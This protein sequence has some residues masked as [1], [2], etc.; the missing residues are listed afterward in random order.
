ME[1]RKEV[2]CFCLLKEPGH[3]F[4]LLP[5]LWFL[6]LP[7]SPG[8]QIF[9]PGTRT[10]VGR[11]RNRAGSPREESVFVLIFTCTCC[12]EPLTN[13]VAFTSQT[14]LWTWPLR[15]EVEGGYSGWAF[16]EF[17]L[18]DSSWYHSHSAW[19]VHK[20]QLTHPRVNKANWRGQVE[21]PGALSLL[22]SPIQRGKWGRGVTA[23]V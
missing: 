3:V 2:N 6:A 21:P 12:P 1:L 7:Q 9:R 23:K 22:R 16:L 20:F 4:P 5:N 14:S 18:P 17:L 8:L 10:C 15:N 11:T 13:I 19:D